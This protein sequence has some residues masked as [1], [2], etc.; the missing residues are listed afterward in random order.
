MMSSRKT[1]NG[2]GKFQKQTIEARQRAL[3]MFY[4]YEGFPLSIEHL[5][6]LSLSCLC[7]TKMRQ[8]YHDTCLERS[9]CLKASFAFLAKNIQMGPN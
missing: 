4:Y 5:V 3:G 1:E 7:Y 2:T 8:C 6:L 9:S